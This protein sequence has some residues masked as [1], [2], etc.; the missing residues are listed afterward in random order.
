[1]R[2]DFGMA[3]LLNFGSA[4]CASFFKKS[5]RRPGLMSY[6]KT[7]MTD[8]HFS[9]TRHAIQKSSPTHQGR[10]K[11]ASLVLPGQSPRGVPDVKH[12][13]LA[14]FDGIKD[15]VVEPPNIFA[16]HA[17]FLRLLRCE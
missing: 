1:M 12:D 6:L 9:L 11:S 3:G 2:T 4:A 7:A 5:G 10:K 16:A 14:A 8:M 15:G 13:N 17:L